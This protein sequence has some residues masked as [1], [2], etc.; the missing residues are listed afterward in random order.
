MSSKRFPGK[1]MAKINGIPMIQMVWEK[2]K[3]SRIGEVYVACS[4]QE[5]FELITNIGG[6]AVLT[7]PDLPTG[8]DRIYQA[9]KNIDSKDQIDA[10]I[11]LQGDMPLIDPADI[12]KVLNPLKKDFTISTLATNLKDDQIVNPN[13]TK[14]EV[15]WVD[16]NVGLAKDFYRTKKYINKNTFHHVGIYGYTPN[17]LNKFTNMKKS[18]NEINLNL[19]QFR[20]I[21]ANINIG[22]T[23]VPNI[24]FG[25]D[26]K[27]DLIE[28]QNII[29]QKN[30]KNK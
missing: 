28:A 12:Q 6:N 25:I 19:E 27:E 22:V 26:T 15:S 24:L 14:V 13:V 11:N 10:I 2:A 9:F 4:E 18:K 3:A 8:T 30:E 23:Y 29:L 21:D 7:S 5:V 16:N 20:A 1:P 17:S